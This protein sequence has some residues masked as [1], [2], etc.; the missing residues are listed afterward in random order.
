MPKGNKMKR[1][2]QRQRE[3]ETQTDRQTRWIRRKGLAA[4]CRWPDKAGMGGGGGGGAGGGAKG[5]FGAG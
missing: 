3:T 1:E 4:P 5:R 2:R